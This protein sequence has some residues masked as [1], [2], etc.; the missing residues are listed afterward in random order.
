MV[1][2]LESLPVGTVIDGELV[3]LGRNGVPRF[4]LLLKYRNG[5]AHLMPF[6]FDILMREGRDMTKRPLSERRSVLQSMVQRNSHVDLGGW[7]NDLYARRDS[8]K[9][10]GIAKRAN[11]LYE[12]GKSSGCWMKLRYNCRQKFVIGG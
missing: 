6:A 5:T 9:Q 8:H 10:E 4:N 2:E 12:S 1:L 3:A 11:S 7:S